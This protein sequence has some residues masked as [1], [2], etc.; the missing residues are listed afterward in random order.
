MVNENGNS[1]VK[2]LLGTHSSKKDSNCLNI[3]SMEVPTE[4]SFMNGDIYD[5]TNK[6]MCMDVPYMQY[7]WVW[8]N[9]NILL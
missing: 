6:G 7:M 4:N 1:E 3:Y 9:C 5:S 2:V 8:I